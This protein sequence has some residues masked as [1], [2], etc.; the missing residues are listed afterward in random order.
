MKPVIG[1]ACLLVILCTLQ[2]T[3]GQIVT[4]SGIDAYSTYGGTAGISG[5]GSGFGVT[6]YAEGYDPLCYAYGAGWTSATPTV[7]GFYQWNFHLLAKARALVILSTG[8]QQCSGVG[9]VECGGAG[10]GG[11]SDSLVAHA[12]A[13]SSQFQGN[14]TIPASHEPNDVDYAS[15]T[16]YC[17]ALENVATTNDTLASTTLVWASSDVASA[18]AE[19]S[20]TCGMN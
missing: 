3:F 4:D 6:A 2:T 20:N 10:P 7:G 19:S 16:V 15:G 1:C 17:S 8:Y 13:S 14:Y 18:S 11:I 5:D 9:H 12:Y